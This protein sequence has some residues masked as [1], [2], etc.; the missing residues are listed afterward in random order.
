LRQLTDFIKAGKYPVGLCDGEASSAH[1][2]FPDPVLAGIDELLPQLE[3]RGGPF[4]AR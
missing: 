3:A 2:F 4:K 1:N